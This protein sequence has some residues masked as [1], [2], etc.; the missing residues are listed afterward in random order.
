MCDV[1]PLWCLVYFFV[2]PELSKPRDPGLGCTILDVLWTVLHG[3]VPQY[4][5]RANRETVPTKDDVQGGSCF[6]LDGSARFCPQT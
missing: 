3:P 1:E 6:S 2:A 5:A 4:L